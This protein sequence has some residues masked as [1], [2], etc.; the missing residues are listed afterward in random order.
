MDEKLKKFETQDATGGKAATG[1][2]LSSMVFVDG[3][4]YGIR[5]EMGAS[6]V[7]LVGMDTVTGN[8]VMSVKEKG[9]DDAEA[10]VEP[11]WSKDCV[12]VRIQD[13]NKFEVWQVDV[14]AKK[15]VR[16]T[17]LEGYGRL[18]EYGDAS[19]VWQG[20]YQAIWAYEKR[21]LAAPGI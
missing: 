19:A 6:T 4:A 3:T 9:Y 8:E 11:S 12:A 17:R 21:K 18:G 14:K 10:Y 16:K 1:L 15:L 13:G 5:Y 7:T 20:P 2:V